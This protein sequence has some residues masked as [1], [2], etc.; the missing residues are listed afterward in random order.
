MRLT[1]KGRSTQQN[2]DQL[3]QPI[4]L[5]DWVWALRTMLANPLKSVYIKA[6]QVFMLGTRSLI[7]FYPSFKLSDWFSLIYWETG[8]LVGWEGYLVLPLV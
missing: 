7:N 5:I 3:R 4:L 1:G 6:L 2:Q 8:P